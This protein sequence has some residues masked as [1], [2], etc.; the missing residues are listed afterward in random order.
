MIELIFSLLGRIN[1][2]PDTVATLSITVS[3]SGGLQAAG[4]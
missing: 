4:F 2:T 3:G 1:V